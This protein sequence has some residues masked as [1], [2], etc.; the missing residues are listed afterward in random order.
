MGIGCTKTTGKMRSIFDKIKKEEM[1]EKAKAR[2][3]LKK[4]SKTDESLS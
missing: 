2:R 3:E 1:N 4:G